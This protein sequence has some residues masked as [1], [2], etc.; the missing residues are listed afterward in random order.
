MKLAGRIALAVPAVF[1]AAFVVGPVLA[2][3]SAVG[4]V[5][6]AF[7]PA[8]ITVSAG[9][10]VTWTV[11]QSIGEPH[12]VTSGTPQDSGKQFDSGINLKDNGQSFEFT[13]KD[14][15]EYLYYCEVHPTEMTGKV[16]V[17]AEGASPPPSV[18]PP[19]SEEKTGVPAE[20]RLLAGTVLVIALVLMF[21][22]AWLWR[23]MN[24]A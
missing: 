19:P 20:R 15:G 1:V 13:F 24:P 21:A 6:K 16:V 12:S 4:I 14:P 5:G 2:A 7:D 3:G 23:R 17:L 9:D 11:N 8:T 18:E 10:T 22:G